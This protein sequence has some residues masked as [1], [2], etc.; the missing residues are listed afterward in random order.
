MAEDEVHGEMGRED[1]FLG[2][3][4]RRKALTETVE[5]LQLT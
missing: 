3:Q 1:R 2:V 5:L 4:E